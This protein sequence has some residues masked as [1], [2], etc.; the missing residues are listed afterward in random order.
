[1]S[2]DDIGV[3][4]AVVTAA[5]LLLAGITKLARPTQWRAESQEMGVSTVLA[6]PVP[7]VEVVLGAMLLVQLQRHAIAWVAVA[8]LSVF[9]MLLGVR[10]AQGKRPRCACFGSLSASPIGLWH[11]ARNAAFIAIAIVAAV[12]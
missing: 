8:L 12:V 10:L 3:I 6:W 1:M 5:V 11:I 9:T 4:A 2:S 7:Y